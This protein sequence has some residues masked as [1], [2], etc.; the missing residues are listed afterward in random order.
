MIV[1]ILYK[2]YSNNKNIYNKNNL[3]A[4][5]NNLLDKEF[6]QFKLY[7]YCINI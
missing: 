6:S 1:E 2:I 4:I 3:H 7:K 5:L